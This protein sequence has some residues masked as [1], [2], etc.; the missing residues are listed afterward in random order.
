MEELLMSL[1]ELL[2]L[3]RGS[4]G[5]KKSNKIKP[6]EISV[7][8]LTDIW[9]LVKH[10]T[11]SHEILIEKLIQVSLAADNGVWVGCWLKHKWKKC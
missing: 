9:I 4:E 10:L 3:N 8:E 2:A 7:W 1:Y 5:K 11:L 6:E